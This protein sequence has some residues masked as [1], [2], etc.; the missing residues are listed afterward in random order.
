MTKVIIMQ[1]NNHGSPVSEASQHACPL[2][3]IVDVYDLDALQSGH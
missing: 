3:S 1:M 2:G